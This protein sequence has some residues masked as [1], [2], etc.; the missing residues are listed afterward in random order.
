MFLAKAKFVLSFVCLFILLKS[1]SYTSETDTAPSA[2][3]PLISDQSTKFAHNLQSEVVGLGYSEEVANK[4]LQ[5]IDDWKYVEWK[6]RLESIKQDYEAKRIDIQEAAKSE[7]EVIVLLCNKI[8]STFKYESGPDHSDLEKTVTDQKTNCL[9]YT[10]LVFVIG[11]SLGL[12]NNSIDVE[13]PFA[14]S[15]TKRHAA[16]L[17]NLTDKQN[18]MVDLFD[19]FISKPFN[20]REDFT[21]ENGLWR[22]KDKT[23]PLKIHKAFSIWDRNGLAAAI[24]SNRAIEYFS[25]GKKAEAIKYATE[26]IHLDPTNSKRYTTRG[27]IYFSLST[28]TESIADFSKAIELNNK[29]VQAYYSRGSLYYVLED[30]TKA[31]PDFTKVIEL[32]PK[33]AKAYHKRGIAYEELNEIDKA[34]ADALEAKRLGYEPKMPSKE[35]Q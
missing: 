30:Y 21:N 9:G 32:D 17:F 23:N 3:S 20:L 5:K 6:H 25:S 8:R 13:E 24:C 1:V 16:C 31:I 29:N 15:L 22:I 33:N 11:N 34:K 26:A 4:L 7:G 2:K 28:A 10:Q 27:H 19:G 18:L 35:D 12:S 14:G